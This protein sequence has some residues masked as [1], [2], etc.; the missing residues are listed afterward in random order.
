MLK[1]QALDDFL[2]LDSIKV[3]IDNFGEVRS[4]CEE[5]YQT[6]GDSKLY[7]KLLEKKEE[8]FFNIFHP[9]FRPKQR[10]N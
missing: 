1:A 3:T 8:E 4:L 2:K 9:C 6:H 5:F 10:W 7:L